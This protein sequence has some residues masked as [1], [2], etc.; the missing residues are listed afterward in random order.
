[1]KR[2]SSY[3]TNFPTSTLFVVLEQNMKEKLELELKQLEANNLLLKERIKQVELV[4]EVAKNTI[5]ERYLKDGI[6]LNK[7]A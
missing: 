6:S 3:L 2:R 4:I 7:V 5:I 1:M